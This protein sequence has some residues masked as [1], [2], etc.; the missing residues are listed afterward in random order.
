MSDAPFDALLGIE[1]AV[2]L[3]GGGHNPAAW[4]EVDGRRLAHD[5]RVRGTASG[6]PPR[7]PATTSSGSASRPW[8]S[9]PVDAWI[10]PIRTVSNSGGRLRARLPGQLRRCVP[11]DPAC[12]G[13]AATCG[14]SRSTS[15]R[16]VPRAGRGADPD[17]ADVA[18]SAPRRLA[19][20]TRGRLAV[21]AHF[22]QPS[23]VDPWTGEVPGR[24]IGGAVPRLECPGRRRVLPA[25]RRARQPRPDLVGPR[26]D[27]RRRGS[28]PRTRRRIGCFVAAAAPAATR[29]PRPS[30]TRSCRSPRPPIGE[31][32][33]GGACAS[34]RSASAG[35]RRAV[36]ARDG[37]RHWPTL[38]IARRGGRP[39]HDPRAV[40]GRRAGD[41]HAPAV[42]GRRSAA[43]GRSSS[44]STTPACRRRSRSSR[45]RRRTPTASPASGSRPRLRRRRPARRPAAARADRHGRR[46]VRP[47]PAVPRP[48]PPA[49]ARRRT[50]PRRIAASTSSPSPRRS[51]SD[52]SEPLPVVRI[53]ERT[54]WSC[55]HGVARWCAECPD[56]ADGRWKGPLRA[57]FERL[58]GGIDLATEAA[59]AGLPGAPDPWAAR[60]AWVDVVVG[61]TTAEAFVAE[62]L[63]S[64]VGDRA[65]TRPRSS[66]F[67]EAQ[68]WRL[69]M[70]AS[71]GWFWDDPVRVETRAGAA[72]GGA[73]G[74][75]RRRRSR[76]RASSAASSRTCRC[77]SR[78]RAASTAPRSTDGPRR[79]RASRVAGPEPGNCKNPLAILT[80]RR[81]RRRTG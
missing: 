45:R 6:R 36:A 41:R 50:R 4:H 60:D 15:R 59:F 68:R 66:A 8:S 28:R 3:L 51:S 52:P 9:R 37:R 63:R 76:E 64:A 13:R 20:V 70:F 17:V 23:R 30:T 74:A 61:A 32:R 26:A 10:A 1:F 54:S 39:L 49:P 38:R 16:I 11:P 22:Y 53:A 35:A 44:S 57:A 67:L 81:G 27:A 79:C 12:P 7:R 78:R 43:G 2:M 29:W 25:Q 5:E 46:A 73:G 21:H 55:H 77:S 14:S 56:A 71:D 62:R 42:P 75:P 48:V 31:R 72:G 33:S 19:P 40:A 18:R 58:A 69:A 24:A 47:P 80:R 34:S 65:P